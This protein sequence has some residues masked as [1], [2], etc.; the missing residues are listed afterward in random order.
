MKIAYLISAYTD[1]EQLGRMINALHG[2]DTYFYIHVDAKVDRR[3]FEEAVPTEAGDHV[4]FSKKRYWI[5]WG[6]WNQVRYQQLL[7]SLAL[8]SGIDFERLFILTAQDYPLRSN[9]Q[10]AEEL[11]SNPKKE[12][13]IG[14]DISKLAVA[15]GGKERFKLTI[16]HLFRDIPFK[17]SGRM[18]Y[19]SRRLMTVLPYRRRPFMMI[20][21]KRVDVFHS[22]SY[23]CI[24]ADFARYALNEMENNK[25]LMKWLKITFVAEELV[26]PTIAFNSTF[27]SDCTLYGKQQYDG[28]KYLSAVTY[29]NYGKQIQILPSTTT[30]NSCSRERCSAANVPPA[31]PTP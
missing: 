16:P 22:S 8:S 24:T 3:P 4:M 23:M 7:L 17:H 13:I 10:I 9:R 27:A 11:S 30:T 21:G 28:L 14:L 6:G 25:K 26:I 2:E 5:N 18:A 12:Y 29:F 19:L 31:Y 1:P 15:G 20:A